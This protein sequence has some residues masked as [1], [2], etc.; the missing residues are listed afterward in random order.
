MKQIRVIILIALGFLFS[1]QLVAQIAIRDSALNINLLY[2]SYGF[3]M[4]SG[5]LASRFG[6]SNQLGVGYTYQAKNGWSLTAEGNFIFRDGVKNQYDILSGISTHDGFIIN[7]SG[8]FANVMLLQRGF[9]LWAKVGK[10]VPVF[11]PNPNSGLML[12]LG[13]GMMQHKIKI[14]IPDNSVP[15]LDGEYKKG[16]DHLCNGPAIMQFIGY[17]H[18]SNNKRLNFFAGAEFVQA[19]TQSRRAYYFNEMIKAD[20]KRIDILSTLKIG[21][22]IPLYKKTRDRYFYY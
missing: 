12:Q 1:A 3:G 19:F 17:Q 22:Y 4:P 16:Y 13:A 7:N 20:E 2:A 18:L 14:E 15:Q 6:F 5:D 21:W 8:V 11:G 10:I 9:T